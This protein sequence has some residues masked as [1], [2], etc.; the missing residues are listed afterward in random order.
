MT[1]IPCPNCGELLACRE[2]AIGRKL[3]CPGC[4][5]MLRLDADADGRPSY[6]RARFRFPLL[7]VAIAGGIFLSGLGTGFLLGHT[8][9]DNVTNGVSVS[10]VG[11]FSASNNVVVSEKTFNV[12]AAGQPAPAKPGEMPPAKR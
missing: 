10:S 3:R 7:R 2:E 5:V 6:G 9:S 8:T 12:P 4:R 1:Q 11:F